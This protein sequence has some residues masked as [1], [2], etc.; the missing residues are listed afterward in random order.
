MNQTLIIGTYPRRRDDYPLQGILAANYDGTGLTGLVSLTELTSPSWVAATA[1][2]RC[3]YA[4][5]ETAPDGSVTA[6]RDGILLNTVGSGGAEPAHLELDPAERFVVVA[7]YGG[8]SVSVLAREPSGRL[9]AMTGHVQHQGAAGVH[10]RQ[11]APHPHQICFDPVSGDLFVPD[12]GLDAVLRY[13]LD[14]GGALT[15]R[16]EARLA[17]TRGAGP[18]HLIFHDD[19]RHLFVVNELNSTL[20]AYRRSGDEFALSDIV[21]TLPDGYAGENYVSAVRVSP[22]GRSV[23]VANRGHD[24]IAVFAFNSGTG[25]LAPALVAPSGGRWPRDAVLTPSGTG[26]LVAN[27]E[28]DTVTLFDFDEERPCLQF[29]SAMLVPGPASLRFLPPGAALPPAAR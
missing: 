11:A 27:Q 29:V 16:R 20:V 28:S 21:S 2:G 23:L 1:D 17:A 4:V 9:G 15:E 7:N 25:K 5:A 12:L 14:A 10:P 6:M 13:R 22:S 8:G 18:R 24:S 3:L 19:G 26:L